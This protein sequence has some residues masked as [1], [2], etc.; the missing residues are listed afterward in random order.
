MKRTRHFIKKHY[1]SDLIR[2]PDGRNVPIRFP[3]PIASS[4]AYDLDAVF[5]GFFARI[6]EIS[7]RG[8]VFLAR[9]EDKAGLVEALLARGVSEV[10]VAPA[11]R[12][13]VAR[14]GAPGRSR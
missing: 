10:S 2:G 1:A 13:I 4:I 12:W 6:E 7:R 3:R 8:I 14:V 5:P 9:E 11:G